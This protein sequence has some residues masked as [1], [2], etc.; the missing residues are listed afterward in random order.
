ML[1]VKSDAVRLPGAVLAA[2]VS[3]VL[4]CVSA[5]EIRFVLNG[6]LFSPENEGLRVV[7]TDG[8]RLATVVAPLEVSDLKALPVI[9]PQ[10]ACR[11]LSGL[12][13]GDWLEVSADESGVRF[14]GD[15]WQLRWKV[16]E[17][18]FPN[19][20]QVVPKQGRVKAVLPRAAVLA[21][22]E[23][24]G[25]PLDK[26]HQAVKLTLAPGKLTVESSLADVG[27][28]VAVVVAETKSEIV[29]AVNGV[30]LREVLMFAEGDSVPVDMVDP[31]SPMVVR[32]ETAA[33]VIMPMRVQ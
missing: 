32:E 25:V 19:W 18:N 16:I 15:G 4:P 29:I 10:A 3:R 20:Q 13:A 1:S 23:F 6:V 14:A 30:F 5:D 8:R 12:D 9:V 22:V 27:E 26:E 2:A 28:A 31:M 21:A 7:A 11:A 24:A 33:A 17:G